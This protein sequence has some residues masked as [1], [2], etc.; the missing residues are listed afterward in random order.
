MRGI[1][2]VSPRLTGLAVSRAG[3]LGRVFALTTIE[4]QNLWRMRIEAVV[5]LAQPPRKHDDPDHLGLLHPVGAAK[6]GIV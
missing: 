6:A 2:F 1:A 5:R 3:S 4:P